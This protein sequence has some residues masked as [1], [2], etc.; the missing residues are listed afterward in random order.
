M[1]T[2]KAGGHGEGLFMSVKLVRHACSRRILVISVALASFFVHDMYT[3]FRLCM[4]GIAHG[5]REK[6]GDE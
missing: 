3:S 4:D 6:E 2:A 1:S 5:K